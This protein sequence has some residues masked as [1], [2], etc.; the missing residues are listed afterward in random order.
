[1]EIKVMKP[2]GRLTWTPSPLGYRAKFISALNNWPVSGAIIVYA[3][4]F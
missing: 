2:Y 3:M 1:M 4:V